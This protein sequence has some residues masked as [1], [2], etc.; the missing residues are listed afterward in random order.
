VT[1]RE[2]NLAVALVGVLGTAG[3]G[4]VAY[5]FVLSPLTEKAKLI[6][7][8]QGE[9]DEVQ[10]QVDRIL[11]EKRKFEGLRQ[12]SLP[13][14]PVQGPGV[15]RT[16]YHNL[17]M[18]LCRRADLTGLK[19]SMS[20]PDSKSAPQI[21]PKK[22]AYTRLT[23]DVSAKGDVYHVA[24]FLR[25]FY[26]QPLLHQIKSIEIRR[27]SDNQ[28]Q[29]RR[30]VDLVMKIEALV[31]DNAP[32]RPTLLPVV[33]EV[34]LLSGPAAYTAVN[35]AAVESGRGSP[36]PPADILAEMP[37]DYLAIAGKN[38]FFGPQRERPEKDPATPPEEDL[39]P[40]VVLTS[41]VGYEDGSY[42]AMFRDLATNNDYTIT[43]DPKGGI[44]VRGEFEINGKKT[45]LPGYSKSNP[46]RMLLYG[47]DEG[48]NLKVWRVRRVSAGEVILEK[49]D[50]AESEEKP[51]PPALAFLGG[52]AGAFVAV[53]EGTVYRVAVGQCLDVHA[54]EREGKSPPHLGPT[55][56]D[57]TREAWKA[58]YAP[59][60]VASPVI[61]TSP[62]GPTTPAVAE[63][64]RR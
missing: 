63:D 50:K 37:R 28:S 4:F 60:Q 53:P 23:W 39:S 26:A 20:E 2:R 55:K 31:L 30:E 54:K 35:M 19:V 52:G 61:P 24:D 44:A 41:V 7:T 29:Q 12:Q 57:L 16:Q 15:A 21:A 18:G 45:S 36:V 56:F 27:P 8:K 49:A 40:F 58:I 46:G 17:L 62:A 47:S 33:R 3:L 32:V 13:A 6:K 43:Q 48:S 10:E 38:I 25:H 14:D 64:R 59:I 5:Q 9:I 11:A 42:I 22:P 34:A 1:T 51:K